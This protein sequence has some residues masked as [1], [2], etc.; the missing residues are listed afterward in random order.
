MENQVTNVQTIQNVSLSRTNIR[1]KSVPVTLLIIWIIGM[2][3]K[4]GVAVIATNQKF[5]TD[6][7]LVGQNALIGSLVT[8]LLF[9]YGIGYFIWGW[10]TDRFGPKRC[11]V[12]GLA[13]RPPWSNRRA[14][15]SCSPK[16]SVPGSRRN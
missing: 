10:L 8:A 15:T 6:M 2:L 13:R 5:L 12:V 4:I 14:M 16:I 11:A 3:D 1:W 9:S 7:H